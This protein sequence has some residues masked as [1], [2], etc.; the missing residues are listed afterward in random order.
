MDEGDSIAGH[1]SSY[2]ISLEHLSA[3]CS[4]SKRPDAIALRSLLS[5]EV[6]IMS[7]FLFLPASY[8]NIIDNLSTKEQLRYADINNR[9]LDWSTNKSSTMSSSSKAY[10]MAETNPKEKKRECTWCKKHGGR[11]QAHYHTECRKL[12]AHLENNPPSN[13][14][15]KGKTVATKNEKAHKATEISFPDE[16]SDDDI[17]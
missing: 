6:K 12:K 8:E 1:V 7:L 9:L 14:K 13:S 10:A 15:N 16:T 2:E 3:R 5:V 17:T 11:Y 4:E